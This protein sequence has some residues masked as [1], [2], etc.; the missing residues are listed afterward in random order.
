LLFEHAE[1][2]VE[3]GIERGGIARVGAHSF[4]RGPEF[5]EAPQHYPGKP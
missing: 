2:R 1:L 4:V 3:R 5:G